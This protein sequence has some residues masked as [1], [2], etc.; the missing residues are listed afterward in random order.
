MKQLV[1]G[2]LL[3]LNIAAFAQTTKKEVL[4]TIDDKPY[5]TDEFT[6]VYNKN[7]DLVKDE[8]QKDLRNTSNCSSFTSS[9]LTRPIN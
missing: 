5:Y 6:R 2:L 3:S 8:S 7:L 4:F 1:L 9:K